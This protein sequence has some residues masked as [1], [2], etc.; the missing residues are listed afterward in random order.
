MNAPL[1]K[2]VDRPMVSIG[3]DGE[4]EYFVRKEL[5]ECG[6]IVSQKQDIYGPTNATR[7]RCVQCE[8]DQHN[9]KS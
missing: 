8:K 9:D 7:R 5:L 2:I 3:D 4:N 1:R 6:H